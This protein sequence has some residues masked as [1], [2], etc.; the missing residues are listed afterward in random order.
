MKLK[1]KIY[2]YT[3]GLGETVFQAKYYFILG[4]WCWFE[5]GIC[6]DDSARQWSTREKLMEFLV[7]KADERRA[8]LFA[9]GR[10]KLANKLTLVVVEEVE[11]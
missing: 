1:F 5:I 11:V 3:N 9:N 10:Q 6:G 8:E 7:L 2:Q 4:L